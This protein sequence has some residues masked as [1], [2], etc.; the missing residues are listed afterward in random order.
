MNIPI[1]R[2]VRCADNI[3]EGENFFTGYTSNK[4]NG[5]GFEEQSKKV[6]RR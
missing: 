4:I 6:N 1:E 2:N 3:K 5:F